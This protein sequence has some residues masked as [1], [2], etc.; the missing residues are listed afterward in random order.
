MLAKASGEYVLF[1]DDDNVIVPEYLERMIYAIEASGKDFAVCRVVH[2]GP[3]NES[4]VGNPP[5][6]LRGIPVKLHHIDTLQVVV[7]RE[8]IQRV[9]WNTELGYLADGHTLQKLG[10]E[11][12]YIE[13]PEVLGFHM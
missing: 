9:G 2:F 8:V 12:E 11:C 4:A 3:L 5:Q 10:D 6:V 1:L 7:K 13:V